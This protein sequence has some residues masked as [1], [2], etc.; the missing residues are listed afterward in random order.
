MLDTNEA[1]IALLRACVKIL[2]LLELKDM[3]IAKH[4]ELDCLVHEVK[5]EW[6]KQHVKWHADEG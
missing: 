3:T 2:S 4:I 6:Q 1:T 5:S